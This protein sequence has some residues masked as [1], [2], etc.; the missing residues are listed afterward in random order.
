MNLRKA[1]EQQQKGFGATEEII[2]TP[3][4]VVKEEVKEEVA[5][6]ILIQ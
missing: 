2:E 3:V 6:S 4:V 1:M 5:M